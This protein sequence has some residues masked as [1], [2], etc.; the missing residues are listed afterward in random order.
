[1]A[2]RSSTYNKHA[3]ATFAPFVA[4]RKG[5]F[6]MTTAPKP[7]ALSDAQMSA[8]IRACDPLLPPDR[9]AFFR[10]LANVLRGEPQPI[11][12]GA[13]FRA[14]RSLQR[15]FF[16]P[17]TVTNPGNTGHANHNRKNVGPAIA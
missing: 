7:L 9:D 11:G 10:A 6:P 12:D 14:V 4:A 3:R 16:R 17:P 15:E 5:G 13:V 8:V 2:G 1:M